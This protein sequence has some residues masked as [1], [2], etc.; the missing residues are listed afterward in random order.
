MN[1]G[2]NKLISYKFCQFLMLEL[3]P[4]RLILARFYNLLKMA[5]RFFPIQSIKK[6]LSYN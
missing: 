2:L 1:L 3:E 6:S 5:E 4:K